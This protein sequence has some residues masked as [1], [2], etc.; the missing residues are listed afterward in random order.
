MKNKFWK[1][2]ALFLG[3][4]FYSCRKQDSSSVIQTN[5]PASEDEISIIKNWL[6]TEATGAITERITISNSLD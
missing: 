5:K 2:I 3:I 4:C 6:S 1:F